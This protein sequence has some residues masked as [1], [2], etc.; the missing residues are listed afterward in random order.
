MKE[1]NEKS[2]GIGFIS[3][4]FERIVKRLAFPRFSGS[5]SFYKGTEIIK[6][7]AKQLGFQP[8]EEKFR[9]SDFFMVQINRLPY[10][11]LGIYVCL[12]SVLSAFNIAPWIKIIMSCILLLMAFT[13]EGIIQALKYP[14]MYSKFAD[15]HESENIILDPKFENSGDKTNL[16]VLAHT[17]TKSE[18]PSPHNLFTIIYISTFVGSLILG[19]HILVFSIIQAFSSSATGHSPLVF[20]YGLLF[21][22]IDMLRILTKYFPGESPGAND[23]A[24]GVAISLHLQKYFSHPDQE[25]ENMNLVCVLTG[26]EELGEAG[27]YNFVKMHKNNLDKK[28]TQFLVL[29]GITGNEIYYFTS[30]GLS[31]KPFSPIFLK[32]VA[33]M[34]S[35]KHP[36]TE[37]IDFIKMWMPPPVNTDH[38]PVME[39]GYDVFVFASPEDVSHSPKDTPENINYQGVAEFYNFLKAL[40]IHI[41]KRL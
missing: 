21:G 30:M 11:F 8:K 29:D 34:R 41:D 7:E 36:A 20:F 32:S 38:S 1:D 26:S 4:E 12:L 25:L 40:L 19:V 33:E 6:E 24:I 5:D 31:K 35:K 17:D 3:S 28:N 2:E 13:I 39:L 10:F 15:L 16:F 14:A 23:D 18:A 9:T 27:A 22:I 37:K